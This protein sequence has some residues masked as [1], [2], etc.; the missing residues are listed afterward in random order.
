MRTRVLSTL[1]VLAA[2]WTVAAETLPPIVG[3]HNLLDGYPA[4]NDDGTVNIV[5]E[6][7]A[8]TIVKWE[9]RPD[10]VLRVQEDRL[11]IGWKGLSAVDFL[12]YPANY[13]MIPGTL[14]A[15]EAGG[16][17]EPLDVMVLGGA[18]ERGTVVRAR[19]IGAIALLDDAEQ[20][21]K[22]LAVVDDSPLGDVEDVADLD[23]RYA[24]MTTIIE[25]WLTSYK[26]PGKVTSYG[27][28]GA[29]AADRLLDAAVSSY[30]EQVAP[31]VAGSGG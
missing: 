13:G 1:L 10:G 24:G 14:M 17:G 30:R 26:G 22:L 9:V 18:I 7:P 21:D 11:G 3:E 29:A 12:A 23:E 19:L 8:G 2:A 4:R 28:I 20:D 31:K 16:D 25:A 15:R 27:F 5:V 6:C